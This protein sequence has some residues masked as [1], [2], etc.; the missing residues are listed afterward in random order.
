MRYESTIH[1]FLY[2]YRFFTFA[3]AVVLTQVIPLIMGKTPVFQTYSILIMLGLYTL[4]KVL[5]PIRWRQKEPLT[6]V[7]LEIWPKSHFQ[8]TILD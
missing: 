6:Y 3:I 5:S 7:I 8:R 1:Q 2:V 4:L